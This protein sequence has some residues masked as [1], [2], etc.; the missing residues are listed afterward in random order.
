MVYVPLQFLIVAV[1]ALFEDVDFSWSLSNSKLAGQ[2]S[3]L[4]IRKIDENNV[5]VIVCF[6]LLY[7]SFL[8]ITSPM[9]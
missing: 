5:Y 7:I 4:K 1:P 2:Y 3:H 6:V 8:V 9:T